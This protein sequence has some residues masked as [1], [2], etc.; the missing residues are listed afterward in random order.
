M[1]DKETPK[2]DPLRNGLTYYTVVAHG[3]MFHVNSSCMLLA[4]IANGSVMELSWDEVSQGIAMYLEKAEEKAR[5][6]AQVLGEEQARQQAAQK[7]AAK[8][9]SKPAA[10]KAEPSEPPAGY[11][12]TESTPPAKSGRNLSARAKSARK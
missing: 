2:F 12:R 3:K 9:A 6:A 1:T 7:P 11:R 10:K 5:I 8:K 4:D